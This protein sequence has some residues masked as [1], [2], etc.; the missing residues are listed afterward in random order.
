MG[1]ILLP[2]ST[3]RSAR[4]PYWAVALTALLL[5]ACSDGTGP[6]RGSD[7]QLTLRVR[8]HLLQ[9]A[10]VSS[11]NTSLT[12]SEVR[13]LFDGANQIWQQGDVV[14]QIESIV[15]QEAQNGEDFARALR[16]EIPLTP[17]LV[18]S[19]LPTDQLL[20]GGWDVYFVR[21]FGGRVGGIYI[22]GGGLSPAVIS[23]EVDPTGLRDLAG[24][25]PRILAH[26]L[27]HSLSLFHVP[28]TDAGNLMAPGCP[29]G[30]RTQLTASQVD[31]ARQQART[32]DPF[33]N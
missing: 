12:D 8:V 13:T 33:G 6:D 29:L 30:R 24:S 27:G 11:L 14:W 17:G 1:R 22:S 20:Q 4:L 28:C 10:E 3:I 16:G 23:S 32:G 18:A 9:D 31:A 7:T 2:P 19:L 15:R 26:E 5:L 21:D 25:G